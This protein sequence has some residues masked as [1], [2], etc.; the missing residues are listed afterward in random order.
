MSFLAKKDLFIQK[1][2]DFLPMDL[3][4]FILGYLL[5]PGFPQDTGRLTV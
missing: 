5:P 2:F 3:T 1:H 4:T